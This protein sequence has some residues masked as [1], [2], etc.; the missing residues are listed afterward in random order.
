MPTPQEAKTDTKRLMRIGRRGAKD[1]VPEGEIRFG[2]T[3]P[4]LEVL[5]VEVVF[6]G[7]VCWVY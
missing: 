4:T 5:L 3:A 2:G 7:G 6:A 1:G